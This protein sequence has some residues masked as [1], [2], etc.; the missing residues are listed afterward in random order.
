MELIKNYD[1]VIDYH[2]RKTNVVVVNALSRKSFVTLAHIR[3]A[4]VPLLL[5]LK[6][7]RINLDYD[8]CGA[9]IASIMVRPT[10]VDQIRGKQMQ[11]DELVKEMH[12][13]MNGE[14]GENF[15]ITQNGVLTMKGKVCVPDVENLRRLIM[16]E[17]HRKHDGLVWGI[18]MSCVPTSE[19]ETSKTS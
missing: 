1:L 4:Y 17:T 18:K 6:T 16:E 5:D 13:I 19:G 9:L 2:P 15:R 7:M 10:L 11:D 8:R 3:T 12:K 14:T